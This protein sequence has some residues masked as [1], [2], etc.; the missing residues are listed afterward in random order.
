MTVDFSLRRQD[1]VCGV[2]RLMKKVIQE[3]HNVG[4]SV[5]QTELATDDCTMVCILRPL[6]FV[7]LLS[8]ARG[9]FL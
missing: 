6:T 4:N 2:D 9:L 5:L 7:S 8:I 1:T 3:A